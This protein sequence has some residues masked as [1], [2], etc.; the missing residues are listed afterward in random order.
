[1]KFSKRGVIF[2]FILLL[3][4][5]IGVN[6]V[7]ATAPMFYNITIEPNVTTITWGFNQTFN[8]SMDFAANESRYNNI[9]WYWLKDDIIQFT[10]TNAT[11]Y[12]GNH[13]NVINGTYFM[14][15]N[16]TADTYTIGSNY[17]CSA[18]IWN[19]SNFNVT[20]STKLYINNTLHLSDCG[21][22]NNISTN[23]YLTKNVQN[24]ITCFTLNASNITFDCKG[25][26]VTYSTAENTGKGFDLKSSNDTTIKNCPIIRSFNAAS[27]T[28]EG[29]QAINSNRTNIINNSFNINGYGG[30]GILLYNSSNAEIDNNTIN[31]T[32][33]FGYAIYSS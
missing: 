24:A 22:I 10:T 29:I 19:G 2:V 16:I 27:T 12:P 17:S 28:T 21:N 25:Y 13:T 30:Y 31:T 26:S 7:L 9:S 11:G 14:S 33:T 5:F 20:N 8:C 3:L 15:I 23:Y 18:A 1:M 4:L 6:N 32:G